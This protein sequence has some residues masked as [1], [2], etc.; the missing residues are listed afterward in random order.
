M[1]EIE[2][3]TTKNI[4]DHNNKACNITK[5]SSSLIELAHISW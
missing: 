4:V 2:I 5:L 1:Q 3:E